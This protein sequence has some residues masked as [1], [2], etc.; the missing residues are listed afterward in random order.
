[1]AI[2][3]G[4]NQALQK[5]YQNNLKSYI[6]LQTKLNN[7]NSNKTYAQQI[8]KQNAALNKINSTIWQD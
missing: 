7:N 3:T 8:K 6:D 5:W 2:F 4:C 1:M